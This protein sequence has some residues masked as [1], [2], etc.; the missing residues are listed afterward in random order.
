MFPLPNLSNPQ[1][2]LGLGLLGAFVLVSLF[3]IWDAFHRE[4]KSTAEKM[5]WIQLA[6]L[7]PFLGGVTYLLFGKRRGQK[8]R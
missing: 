3:S 5:A 4:F 7:V 6:V 8:I 1:W 2:A